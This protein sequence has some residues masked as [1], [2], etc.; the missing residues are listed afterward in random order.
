MH[1]SPRVISALRT[2]VRARF[3]SRA[4]PPT[5][6]AFSEP[7]WRTPDSHRRNVLPVFHRQQD[8]RAVIETVAIFLRPVVDALRRDDFLFRDQRLADAFTEF[9]RAG[10]AGFQR[11]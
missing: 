4:S 7:H 1:A 2:K 11:H 8:A 3:S 5:G 9:R 6:L 10:L